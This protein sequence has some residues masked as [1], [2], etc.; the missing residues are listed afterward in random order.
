MKWEPSYQAVTGAIVLSCM[1]FQFYLVKIRKTCSHSNLVKLW[2]K[3]SRQKYWQFVMLLWLE[4]FPRLFPVYKMTTMTG[5][6]STERKTTIVIILVTSRRSKMRAKGYCF[7]WINLELNGDISA[8]HG[9]FLEWQEQ[10]VTKAIWTLPQKGVDVY[11]DFT[12]WFC[13]GVGSLSYIKLA[14]WCQR[15]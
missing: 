2:T 1:K 5:C 9:Y 10:Y 15:M 7:K 14:H 13:Y 8:F 11:C 4:I 6:W 3:I 12:S